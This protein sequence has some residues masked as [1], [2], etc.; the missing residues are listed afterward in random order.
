MTEASLCGGDISA[1]TWMAGACG[2]RRGGRWGGGAAGLGNQE[3][4]S[5]EAGGLLFCCRFPHKVKGII[6][7]ALQ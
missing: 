4:K 2:G 6:Q 1:E 5:P 3:G 7:L